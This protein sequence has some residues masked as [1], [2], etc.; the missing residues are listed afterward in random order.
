MLH[1][2]IQ[3]DRLC[4]CVYVLFMEDQSLQA[5][6]TA[7]ANTV[8]MYELFDSQLHMAVL[9]GTLWMLSVLKLKLQVITK[10]TVVIILCEWFWPVY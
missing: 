7:C 1:D 4:A 9:I 2:W 3:S 8:C 6:A 5:E 10:S